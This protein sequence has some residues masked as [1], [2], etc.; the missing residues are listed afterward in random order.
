MWRA[1]YLINAIVYRALSK[2]SVSLEDKHGN[3]N[4]ILVIKDSSLMPE[5]HEGSGNLNATDIITQFMNTFVCSNKSKILEILSMGIAAYVDLNERPIIAQNIA[6]CYCL[7]LVCRETGKASLCHIS[8]GFSRIT[9]SAN[10]W[11]KYAFKHLITTISKH[12]VKKSDDLIH[13]LIVGGQESV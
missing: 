11:G 9:E 2:P 4:P 6:T 5:G 10:T 8:D 1:E 3:T 7:V 13:A 12:L